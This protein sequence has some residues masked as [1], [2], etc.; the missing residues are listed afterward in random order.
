MEPKYLEALWGVSDS[1]IVVV[2]AIVIPICLCCICF[3]TYKVFTSN[4]ATSTKVIILFLS[5]VWTPIIG[6]KIVQQS[7]PSKEPYYDGVNVIP[8]YLSISK[9]ELAKHINS[10]IANG[11][12]IYANSYNVNNG[13]NEYNLKTSQLILLE[14]L[15]LVLT[16]GGLDHYWVNVIPVE[17]IAWIGPLE[18]IQKIKVPRRNYSKRRGSFRIG[19][20][21]KIVTKIKYNLNIYTTDEIYTVL[22]Q[23]KEDVERIASELSRHL[24]GNNRFMLDDYLKTE[25]NVDNNFKV[26][27]KLSDHSKKYKD[28]Y[29]DILDDLFYLKEE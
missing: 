27:E 5:W 6:Y 25:F 23:T 29:K 9:E 24:I 26:S 4:Y 20:R 3:A 21:Y 2:S 28:D 8:H 18:T 16:G 1:N 13:E 14:D 12:Y 17:E 11:K 22:I 7:Y 15:L 10:E 19:S